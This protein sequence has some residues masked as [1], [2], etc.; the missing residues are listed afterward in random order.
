[1]RCVALIGPAERSCTCWL[2]VT[3]EPRVF[4]AQAL[5]RACVSD[6]HPEQSIPAAIIEV[7]ATIVNRLLQLLSPDTEQQPSL[8]MD[9]AAI[10]FAAASALL[11]LARAHDALL[12]SAA[13]H[14]L[15]LVMQAR[16]LL[17]CPKPCLLMRAF[18]QA[19][20]RFV[21]CA[22]SCGGSAS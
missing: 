5:A 22:G 9:A 2:R 3:A 12:P 4:W 11:R 1:M 19:L 16:A 10:R 17:E 6:G 21:P 18:C 20:I 15:A 14:T 13:Y 7:S 8:A